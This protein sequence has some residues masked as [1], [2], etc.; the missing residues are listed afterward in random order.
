[1]DIGTGSGEHRPFPFH[2][3]ETHVRFPADPKALLFAQTPHLAG[4]PAETG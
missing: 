2:L 1:M 3:F 4:H